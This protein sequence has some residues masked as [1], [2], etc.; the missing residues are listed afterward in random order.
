MATG[1]TLAPVEG[2]AIAGLEACISCGCTDCA[3][4]PAPHEKRRE[5]RMA[6]SEIDVS[7]CK[8]FSIEMLL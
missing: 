7:R 2:T 8:S 6:G 4:A 1:V 3:A 5:Q